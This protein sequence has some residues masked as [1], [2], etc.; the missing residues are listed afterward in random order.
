MCAAPEKPPV[1][2]PRGE[3]ATCHSSCLGTGCH[4][5]LAA[6]GGSSGVP[7][8]PSQT[9]HRPSP[10]LSCSKTLVTHPWEHPQLTEG[11]G[12]VTEGPKSLTQRAGG[13]LG[14]SLALLSLAW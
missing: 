11:P 3:Q 7:A 1:S 8:R 14:R 12:L 13:R 6:R 5:R 9:A 10:T 2:G 4:S